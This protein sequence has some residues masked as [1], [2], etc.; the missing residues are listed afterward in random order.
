MK[1]LVTVHL[2]GAHANVA[3]VAFDAWYAAEP[4]KTYVSRIAH[5]EKPVRG[6]LDLRELPCVMQLLR[7]HGLAPE[8]ILFEGFVHLDANETPGLG[9]HLFHALGSTVPVVGVSKKSLP[10]L[11]AQVEVMRE[12]EAPPLWVT[13]A[14]I[15]IG[16]AKARLRAM[17]GRKRVPTL[18]KLAARLAKNTD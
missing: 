7:E 8:L 18:M 10:G 12:E 4:T 11:S 9:Q 17:H 3:A 1:L 14:G 5:V 6:E 2:D 13:C 15:D 16:A